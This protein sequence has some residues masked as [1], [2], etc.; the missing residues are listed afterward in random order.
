[1][2]QSVNA[3]LN[4][5]VQRAGRNV[6]HSAALLR[7]VFAE[8]PDSA[9]QVAE[10]KA[11]EEMGDHI[12]HE[13]ILRLSRRGWGRPF[14]PADGHALATELDDIVDHAEQTADLLT[15]YGIEAPMVQGEELADLLL[16]ASEEVC[17]CLEDLVAK[18]YYAERL[19]EIDR[20]EK[21][22]DRVYR[23]ALAALFAEGID[24]T[25][26]IRWKDVFASLEQAIDACETVAHRLEGIALKRGR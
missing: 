24:P 19:T 10:L 17:A 1:M 2:A 14:S 15:L 7:E 23:D 13:L 3:Q 9:A 20:L 11:C 4:A 25:T 26:V 6:A 16:R 22:A 5:L 12:T 18:R 21:E 8:H